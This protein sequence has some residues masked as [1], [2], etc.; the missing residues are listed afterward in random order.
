MTKTERFLSILPGLALFFSACSE[1]KQPVTG[2]VAQETFS[3]PITTVSASRTDAPTVDAPV[4]SDG[5]FTLNLPK[6][7]GYRLDFTSASGGATLV[8]PRTGGAVEWRFDVAS[9]GSS[10]DLGTVRQVGDPRN[11]NIT[12]AHSKVKKHG[13]GGVDEC[14]RDVECVNGQDPVTGAVCVEDTKDQG[15]AC[16]GGKGGKHGKGH[17]KGDHGDAGCGKQ[18]HDLC[19]GDAGVCQDEGRG[20]HDHDGGVDNDD[21]TG[22]T[23]GD[24]SGEAAPSTAAV[25]DR[26]LPSALGQCIES[27]DDTDNQ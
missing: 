25:A 8:F 20:H 4:A 6:G 13:D 26:N 9:T 5:T 10:F 18:G 17:G 7:T 27:D 21:D 23:T 11:L 1:S 12:F 2:T 15:L 3:S 24:T 14:D 16:K 19:S 22:I